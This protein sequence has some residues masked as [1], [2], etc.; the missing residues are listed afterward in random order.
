MFAT[1]LF[2]YLTINCY[3]TLE[4]MI[5]L[6]LPELNNYANRRNS[7]KHKRSNVHIFSHL[8]TSLDI[9]RIGQ[10]W[11]RVA[12]KLLSGCSLLPM[13]QLTHD[14]RLRFQKQNLLQ[15]H[16]FNSLTVNLVTS[17]MPTYLSKLILV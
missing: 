2:I 14:L 9:M 16:T 4:I 12:L 8:L 1:K 15:A 6:R 17:L 13:S 10:K 3:T 11:L 7:M 5:N